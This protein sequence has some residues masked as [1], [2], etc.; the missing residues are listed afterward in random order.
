MKAIRTVSLFTTFWHCGNLNSIIV[1][2]VLQVNFGALRTE[3][4]FKL[5]IFHFDNVGK[6]PHCL[7]FEN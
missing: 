5:A 4:G 6:I 7:L 1:G 2:L 3:T